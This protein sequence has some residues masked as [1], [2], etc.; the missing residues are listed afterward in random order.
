MKPAAFN[1]ATAIGLVVALAGVASADPDVSFAPHPDDTRWWLSGQ[2][3]IITQY[4]PDFHADYSGTNSLSPSAE[5]ATSLVATIFGGFMLTSTTEVLVDGEEA[6]GGGLSQALGLAGFTNLDVVRN[7][8]L[9]KAPYLA[10]AEIHQIIPLSNEMVAVDRGPLRLFK[11]LPKRRLEIRAGK[12]STVDSFDLNGSGTDSHLQ[13]MNWAID[14][15]GAYDYAA[16]TRGYTLGAI[17]EYQDVNWAVRYGALLMPTV[18]NGI[19]YDYGI[20]HAREDV[21]EGEYRQTI[22]GHH[23]VVR[24]LAFLNQAK[25]GNYAESTLTFLSGEGGPRPD[26]TDSRQVGRTKYGFGLNVEQEIVDDLHVFGR[27]GWNDGKNETFA[28]TEIDNTMLV[29]FDLRG[30]RWRRPEDKLGLAF[31]SNGLSKEHRDY[32]GYGGLGFLLG[33]GAL[34]YGRETIVEA[35]YTAHVWKGFFP[36]LDLQVIDNPGYN[37]DRGPVVVGSVR[38][39]FEF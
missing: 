5:R 30:T 1:I 29:G 11:S 35:Y 13:F 22:A 12:L 38:L 19:D 26:I 3:N 31:V 28:Y 10:R 32:L 34:N 7:P 33:D 24:A 14:N 37:V 23:G 21:V 27:F 2:A 39:H 36:A 17:I 6:S 25:M 15:N 18:A 8:T 20:A 16:D 9:S 4:H